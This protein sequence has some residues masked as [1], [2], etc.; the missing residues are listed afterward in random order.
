MFS[1]TKFL[2]TIIVSLVLLSS[3]KVKQNGIKPD[4]ELKIQQTGGVNATSV[5]WSPDKKMWYTVFGG[6]ASFPLEV[7]DENGKSIRKTSVGFDARGLWW[8]SNT[9][10]IEGNSFSNHGIIAIELT[11]KGFPKGTEI[12]TQNNEQP[13]DQSCG[14]FDSEKNEI[15]YFFNDTVY[16][17]NRNTGKYIDRMGLIGMK[18]PLEHINNNSLIFTGILKK[19]IGLLDFYEKKI[20]LF[21]KSNGQ[22]SETIV[23]SG[24][25]PTA[26]MYRFSYA[27][28][29]FWLYDK[30]KRIWFGYKIIQ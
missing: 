2:F 23:L 25:S 27:N 26:G 19:E 20:Y 30:S 21:D 3:C 6:N 14:A 4:I 29:H 8:N 1:Q 17:Y 15:L 24:K 18:A 22:L 16:R 28:E 9:N 12:V 10:Q 5:V 11:D 7:F 13:A